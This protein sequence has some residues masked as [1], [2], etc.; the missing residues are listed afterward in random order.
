MKKIP[1]PDCL[2]RKTSGSNLRKLPKIPRLSNP[3]NSLYGKCFLGCDICGAVFELVSIPTGLDQPLPLVRYF[4]TYRLKK[5]KIKRYRRIISRL[6]RTGEPP[7]ICDVLPQDD[8]EII[9]KLEERK[10]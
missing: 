8:E 6:N 4:N 1:C 10:R 9:R 3:R 7:S 2:R 5:N